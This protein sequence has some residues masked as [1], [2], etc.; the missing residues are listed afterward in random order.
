M[1]E[2]PSS[3]LRNARKHFLKCV[4]CGCQTLPLS[5]SK[6]CP[7]SAAASLY[8]SG[9]VNEGAL[10]FDCANKRRE[11]LGLQVEK[12]HA[13]VVSPASGCEKKLR[14]VHINTHECDWEISTLE[15]LLIKWREE[16]QVWGFRN[17]DM[18]LWLVAVN[19][20]IIPA[21][22]FGSTPISEGDQI[23]IA[24]GAVAGG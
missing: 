18:K 14:R 19:D 15:S 20:Q 3:V 7:W 17:R 24:M 10:C 13:D 6:Q 5:V 22:N 16:G 8:S 23:F 4:D 1:S 2:Y 21:S 12:E 9:S 11:K